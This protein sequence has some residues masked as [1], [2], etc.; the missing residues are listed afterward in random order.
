MVTKDCYVE[1]AMERLTVTTMRLCSDLLK[2]DLQ[3]KPAPAGFSM[4]GGLMAR[5]GLARVGGGGPL[6]P[7]VP[8]D[9]LCAIIGLSGRKCALPGCIAGVLMGQR[10]RSARPFLAPNSQ[11]PGFG[12]RNDIFRR[13][14]D[15]GDFGPC[16]GGDGGGGRQLA[17]GCTTPRDFMRFWGWCGRGGYWGASGI[18]EKWRFS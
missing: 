11:S 8:R 13:I 10:D 9:F 5:V 4:C 7:A 16:C 14:A 15:C 12:L 1:R 2:M 6:A 18:V 3:E 17:A